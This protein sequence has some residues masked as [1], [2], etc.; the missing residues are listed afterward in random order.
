MPT[1]RS[2]TAVTSIRAIVVPAFSFQYP[3]RTILPDYCPWSHRNDLTEHRK[4]QC[5]RIGK[6]KAN[7]V[8]VRLAKRIPRISESPGESIPIML[9]LVRAFGRHAEVV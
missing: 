9:G 4:N 3:N 7:G 6:K 1:R 8:A 5:L 2:S